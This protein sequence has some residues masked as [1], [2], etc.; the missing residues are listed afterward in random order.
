MLERVAEAEQEE[1]QRALDPLAENRGAN[2]RHDHQKVDVE[3]E[4]AA[5]KVFEE[6]PDVV[7]RRRR[8]RPRRRRQAIAIGGAGR[9]RRDPTGECKNSGRETP[10]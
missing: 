6:V 9:A 8:R 1:Q 2:R 7:A 4:V 5:P 3:V 10:R